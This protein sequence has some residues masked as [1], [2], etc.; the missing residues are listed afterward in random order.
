[1]KIEAGWFSKLQHALRSV[2]PQGPHAATAAIQKALHDA[3]IGP[4]LPDLSTTLDSNVN[5]LIGRLGVGIPEMFAKLGRRPSSTV[6]PLPPGARF[7][8][9]TYT[10]QA[11]SRR[12]KLYIPGQGDTSPISAS[13]GTPSPA[14]A[15]IV[16]LHGCT[17]DPDDFAAGTGM[18]AAAELANCLVLYPQQSQS[19]NSSKCWNWFNAKDQQRDA[20]EPSI[21]A[22]MT[23]DVAALHGV[24]PD[25]IYVA[26]LSAGGAMAAILGVTYPDLYAGVGVHSGLPHG[27]ASDLPSALA[28]MNSGVGQA[29]NNSSSRNG[30]QQFR[31]IPIIVFHGDADHT[32]A[33]RN[34]DAVMAQATP[35]NVSAAQSTAMP[36]SATARAYTRTVRRDTTGK[37]VAEQ[38]LLHGLG[39]AWAGGSP[40]GSYTDARG[41]DATGEMLRFFL[42]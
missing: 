18:N 27:A 3:Q 40:N 8:S 6:E 12:Y 15:L 1:M 33:A 23:R 38:W 7:E 22:G 32:V 42:T 20:G 34:G 19:A 26:G 25:R 30:R 11:G 37:V 35:D 5:P 39:H 10:N 17:Q 28:A 41:P 13:S 9:H 24:D 14:P 31:G 36:A 4:G 16:M 21:L 2:T 29:I